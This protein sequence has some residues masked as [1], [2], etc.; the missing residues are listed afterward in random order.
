MKRKPG[1]AKIAVMI[2]DDHP[3]MRN[4]LRSIITH[5]FDLSVVGEAESG[6]AALASVMSIKPD[7]VLVDGSMPG[8][9]G[10]ET[11]RHLRKM[12]PG[13]KIVGLTL[14]EQTT[15]LEEMIEA[16]ANG[17]VLKTGTPSDIITA[18]RTVARGGKYFDP[19]IPRRAVPVLRRRRAPKADV[20]KEQLSVAK[21][22]ANGRSKAE[23]AESLGVSVSRVET[24]C[25]A[26]MRKLQL[27]N[28][29]QLVR[30][31]DDQGWLG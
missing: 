19:S 25:T 15:Y 1:R 26:V 31:A 10:M 27:R 12:A 11:T 2:V 13:V 6:S 9:N 14:Y 24:L 16:G 20:S 23:I 21:H 7:V 22:L 30:L 29:A 28:R 4:A 17:Y 3:M 18:I 8:M 5:E